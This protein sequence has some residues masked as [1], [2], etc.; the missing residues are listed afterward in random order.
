MYRTGLEELR[1]WRKKKD[2]LPLILRGA[3]QVGKSWLVEEFGRLDFKNI[4]KVNF[5]KTPSVSTVFNEDISPKRIIRFLEISTNEKISPT[6][7]LIFLDEI[8]ECP[9]ALTSLKYFAE[10][11]PEYAV[12][13]AGSLLGIAEH[14][15]VS[16]PVGKVNFMNLFP[17]SFE[18]FLIAMGDENLASLL[19]LSEITMMNAFHNR[20]EE[21]LREYMVVGG[22][23]AVVKA[24]KENHFTDEIRRKQEEIVESYLAD[25]SK[26]APAIVAV[27]SRQI[28]M[29]I[30]S[31]LAKENKKFIY[32]QVRDG[33]RAK[34]Y[35]SSFPWLSSCRIINTVYR[36]T[37]PAI[38]LKAYEEHSVFKLFMHDVG[39][40]SA[41]AN[42]DPKIVLE[43]NSVYDLFKGALTEQ[44]VL[45]E[46]IA[47]GWKNV[48]YYSNDR[49][50]AEI[51]FILE[52]GDSI[53]P[54]EVKSGI[55]L[56]SKSLKTYRDKFSPELSL[57][58]S[59]MP[60]KEQDGL[61]NIP[62]YA[63][64]LIMEICK[65]HG[66]NN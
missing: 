53:I 46:L 17:L 34:D 45:Q 27:R 16:F 2:R 14:E 57:R 52:A 29:S 24:W 43:G 40:L 35:E 8:Q 36:V 19:N 11:A 25:L 56:R 41:L 58:A 18:E 6:D 48:N 60:Y 26:H 31:Q 66:E 62:L 7:T 37:T 61:I 54:L 10:E 33:A 55:N 30:P 23:P 3:R 22:M 13:A 32:S 38:P 5:E 9:R 1:A 21:R 44:Y 47:S 4:V 39:L 42:I 28:I 15:G 59:L 65:K 49:S 51:D 63:T 64:S 12:I 50:T 20:F